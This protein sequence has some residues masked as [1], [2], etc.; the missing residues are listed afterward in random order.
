MAYRHNDTLHKHQVRAK[1][2]RKVAFTF[3]TILVLAVLIILGD[4]TIGQLSGSNT[5]ISRE[6]QTSVQ[7]A[8]VSVYRTEFFQFQ[9]PESWVA[10]SSE[11]TANKFVYVK[12]SGN[13]VTQKF[14][15]FVNRPESNREADFNLTRVV[16][17][18]IGEEGQLER[19]G[20]V[21]THCNDS[22]PKDGNRDPRR[23]VHSE[24]SFVCNPDSQQYNINVG[25]IGG[26]EQIPATLQN[27]KVITLFLVYS[28]LTAYPGTGDLY[29]IIESFSIL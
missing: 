5:V 25:I 4:W 10:V 2:L 16:P 23:I 29:N 18:R 13:L 20:D 15:V 11:S 9:A 26:S 19:T 17:I 24:I 7:S 8:N 6:N 28:D 21:S 1:R 27:G 12:N 14:T 22:F 3:S